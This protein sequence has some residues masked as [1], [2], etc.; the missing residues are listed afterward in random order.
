MKKGDIVLIP[1]PYTD[2]TGN[3][4]RPALV[5]ISS[6]KDITVSFISTQIHLKEYYDILIRPSNT[7]GLKKESLLRLSK[8]ATLDKDLALG[9]LG[10]IDKS[11]LQ[12]INS[13]LK[14]ILQLH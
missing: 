11:Y 6:E 13:N 5:L 2:L 12:L 10:R 7:N 8:I 14:S 9:L 4:N 1:F 3:K